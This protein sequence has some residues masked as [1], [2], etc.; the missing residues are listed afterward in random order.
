MN[1]LIV[2]TLSFTTTYRLLS[3]FNFMK[4]SVIVESVQIPVN[5]T[6]I[7]QDLSSTV[8]AFALLPYPI[9]AAV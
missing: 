9:V 8:L 6:N 4:I 2:Y 3:D 1:K 5:I 7:A